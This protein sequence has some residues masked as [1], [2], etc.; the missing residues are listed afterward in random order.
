MKCVDKRGDVSGKAYVN[1]SGTGKGTWIASTQCGYSGTDRNGNRYD[2]TNFNLVDSVNCVENG[3][4]Q[5]FTTITEAYKDKS[6]TQ[7][8]P[9][10]P[11]EF[12]E[13][14]PYSL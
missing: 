1:G 13:Y 5:G 6:K 4:M 12:A 14:A 7:T 10:T 11:N 3:S 8:Q 2:Y 9:F